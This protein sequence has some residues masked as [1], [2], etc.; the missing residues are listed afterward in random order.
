M[1]LLKASSFKTTAKTDGWSSSVLKDSSG[2]GFLNA[3]LCM[4]LHGAV[5]RVNSWVC[6]RPTAQGVSFSYDKHVPECIK[7][8][9][10][11]LRGTSVLLLSFTCVASKCLFSFFF[12]VFSY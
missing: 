1:L 9:G 11:V 2:Q 5:K 10:C 12:L 7:K 4:A 3:T 6:F 8:L